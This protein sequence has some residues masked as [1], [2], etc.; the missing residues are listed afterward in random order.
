MVASSSSNALRLLAESLSEDI[1]RTPAEE[2]ISEAVHDDLDQRALTSEFDRI[3]RRSVQGARRRALS[4]RLQRALNQIAPWPPQFAMASVGTL[5]IAV[6]AGA[7]YLDRPFTPAGPSKSQVMVPAATVAQ[8]PA[9]SPSVAP[10]SGHDHWPDGSA[11]AAISMRAQRTELERAAEARRALQQTPR[12]IPDLTDG[13]VSSPPEAIDSASATAALLTAEGADVSEQ[14]ALARA[15]A[16]EAT[17]HDDAQAFGIFKR[18]AGQH[19]NDS[20]NSP[21]AHEI[22]RALV[23]LADYFLSGI[24]ATPSLPTGSE[25]VEAS[26]IYPVIGATRAPSIVIRQDAQ[27]AGVLL[28]HAATHFADPEAQYELARLYVDG[29][30]VAKDNEE[31]MR[32]FIAAADQGLP[33]AQASLGTMLVEG[34]G[35][36]KDVGRGL[37]WL[38]LA[39]DTAGLDEGWIRDAYARAYAQADAEERKT[40][41]TSAI[42][43]SQRHRR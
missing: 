22:A 30:G 18:I 34:R 20:A 12:V 11:Q 13:V 19:W 5:A 7:L 10:T 2:L 39:K 35:I 25:K 29:R 4:G 1:L 40:A 43:W 15:L 16:R 33:R 17:A 42:E 38:T 6:V 36:P 9:P 3:F 37:S 28:H 21:H 8:S 41:Q 31:A 24:P 32:W 26:N 23:A 14:L 27:E